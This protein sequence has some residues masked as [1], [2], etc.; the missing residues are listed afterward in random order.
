M[1]RTLTRIRIHGFKTFAQRVEIE[2]NH[3]LVAVVG[4]NGCG[5]SNLVD[6]IVWAL[7]EV[8]V[9]SLRAAT[10]TEVLFSGS[11]T[12]KPLGMAEVTLWF[13]NESRW[14]PLDVDEVQITRR[15]YRSGEWEC[16]INRTPARLREVA[17]LFANTGLGRGGYAI[18]GQG[19]IEA[20]LTA[21][22]DE[23]RRWLEELAGIAFYR[24]RRRDTV[25][26]LESTRIHLQRVE[27]VLR[28][29]ERQREPLREQAERALLYRQLQQ[30]LRQ[31]E[32]QL[33]QQELAQLHQQLSQTL[34]ER[35]QLRTAMEQVQQ[36][37]TLC[38]NQAEAEGQIVARL[39]AEMETLRMLLQ[40][41]LS[42]EER[43]QGDLKAM[44]ERERTLQELRQ[45]LEEE[46]A[47]LREQESRQERTIHLLQA[48][49]QTARAALQQHLPRLQQARAR[50][51][52][53]EQVR[54]DFES[55][56]QQALQAQAQR[57]QRRREQL[58]LQARL[59]EIENAEPAAQASLQ[60]AIHAFET[61]LAHEHA[62]RQQL[63][64]AEADHSEANRQLEM[65]QAQ[66]NALNARISQL[67]ARIQALTASLQ[68]GEGASPAVR[69]LLQ[70]LQRGELQGEYYP[71]GSILT[72]PPELQHAVEAAL[73]ASVNDIITPTEAEA[74]AAI[75]WLNRTQSGRL[76]FLPLN[77]LREGDSPSPQRGEGVHSALSPSGGEG[78]GEGAF[79][80]A[81]ANSP[82]P[83]PS[84]QRG[85][86]E[87]NPL[88]HSVG[89]GA[90]GEGAFLGRMPKLR[91][92]G[93]GKGDGVLGWAAEMVAYEPRFE[94]AVQHLLR[95]TLIV[96]TLENAIRLLQALRRAQPGGR[97]P[98][99]VTLSGELVQPSGVLTGG[100]YG[101]ERASML[102]LKRQLDDA[103]TAL[104]DAQHEYAR[105][106]AELDTLR[107][108]HAESQ[109]RVESLRQALHDSIQR[110]LAAEAERARA[111]HA[112]DQLHR[113]RDRI[114]A[115]LQ[116][117][118]T[119]LAAQPMPDLA[120][121]QTERDTIQQAHATALQALTSLQA[122]HEA[123]QREAEE[124]AARLQ[125]ESQQLEQLRQ[126]LQ[127][128]AARLQAVQQEQTQIQANRERLQH[129]SE[130]L[131]Q[132]IEATQAQL[133]A[134]RAERQQ[135]LENSL[136]FS[137]QAREHRQTLQHLQERDRALELRAARLE[138]RIAELNEQWQRLFG[139]PSPQPS[140]QRGE[141][142]HSALSPSGGEG[143]GEGAFCPAP[144][145]SPSPQPS[146]QR[147]EGETN[148]LS[149]SVGEGAGGEGMPVTRAA[150]E[151]LRQMVQAMGEVNLG[152]ADEYARLTERITTL[153]RQRDDLLQTCEQLEHTLR[154][155]DRH[156][157]QRF[158]ETFEAARV[159][160]RQRFQQLFEGGHADL[161]L[162]DV[163]DPLSAGVLIEAQPPGKR[164]QRL[165]LLSGGERAL[166]ATALLFA[167]MDV[168]PS[169]LCVLD[170]VD[171]ALDGRNVQR[172]AEHLQQMAQ[173]TQVLIV[174]HNP[175]TTAVAQQWIGIALTGG[176][177][178]VVPY[179]P[180]L[181]DSET[182]GLDRRR[183][184]IQ[185]QSQ[186]TPEPTTAPI[187]QPPSTSEG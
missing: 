136:Q 19:E 168:K 160:F 23:R 161:I 163:R 38:E 165:E 144:A 101:S 111:E 27:D 71:V 97:I 30:Q 36:E 84:P 21:E 179:V 145:N 172:F 22:P 39:E 53:L 187:S 99:M 121:L 58:A 88:S 175:I 63:S 133:E 138:V 132:Q 46:T 11:S 32:R 102:A 52:E 25:R 69:R 44:H 151:K 110:R 5:K 91:E 9:R 112:L 34:G 68:A 178:R 45:T 182:D 169:P 119:E 94:R 120:A 122:E 148:P 153:T 184:V 47:T 64:E 130:T 42:A 104:H 17:E 139:D 57:E 54:R 107:Q 180:R 29:L 1:A 98:R 50:V 166:T 142:V 70:A 124:T 116:Q 125:S 128:R 109:Q 8:S 40:N 115:L 24:H 162:T 114:Q 135:H 26:D 174:T 154:D 3:D 108:Q 176:V 78:T 149:H 15:L 2:L 56:Y 13:N 150:V 152:A 127:S 156:A 86:G 76:T 43:L 103:R 185:L 117:I 134:R 123:L 4:P 92:E 82:S 171:A 28:E 31:M 72:V 118:E 158:E 146:P 60:R 48:R 126:R 12:E 7:G 41:Q 67:Q 140:P 81:P 167:F 186:P 93:T 74:R 80:P 16:W 129:D 83:Q 100:R 35:Q 157:R 96:D 137:A 141:G 105:Q 131:L 33:L 75:D 113:E 79:C 51:D 170:E 106:E 95:R 10:P 164:R 37:L 6:A 90:G 87:T 173:S 89:E 77:I 155:I 20:F 85:E 183:A 66:R 177:S 18:V 159:A 181:S 55:R 147:G 61:A 73:G 143:T 49:L 14:L 62:L 65:R 59:Q